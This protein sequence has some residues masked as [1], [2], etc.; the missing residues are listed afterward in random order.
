MNRVIGKGLS[1]NG[2]GENFGPGPLN[3]FVPFGTIFPENWAEP[4]NF[5]LELQMLIWQ[6]CIC[7]SACVIIKMLIGSKNFV[8]VRIPQAKLMMMTCMCSEHVMRWRVT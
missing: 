5:V 3:F 7:L 2:S 6:L 4:K 8:S 1:R